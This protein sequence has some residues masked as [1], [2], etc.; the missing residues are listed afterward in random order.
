[1]AFGQILM[2]FGALETGVKFHDF[3]WLSGVLELS[4]ASRGKVLGMVGHRSNSQ[5]VSRGFTKCKIQH[6]TCKDKGIR[7]NQDA[8]YENNKKKSK[9]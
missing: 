9:L 7:K 8:N 3:R 5:S 1:M 4:T 2:T 6:Q